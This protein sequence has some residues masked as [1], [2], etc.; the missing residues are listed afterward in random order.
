MSRPLDSPSSPNPVTT[1]NDLAGAV[2]RYGETARSKLANPAAAGAPED[3]LRAPLEELVREIAALCGL[4]SDAVVMVGESS[5]SELKTRPDYAVTVRNALVGFIEV[6]APGKGADPR[7]FRERHDKEQWERLQSIPN[8]LY[9]DGNEFALWR[10]GE[11]TG[12]VIRLRGDVR[13]SGAALAAPAALQATF[14]DFLTWE[15]IAPRTAKQLAGVTARLCRL[16]RDE[17]VEQME[18]GSEALTSLATDW[19]R[20]L[21]PDATDE[22]FADGYAQAVTFGLLVAR[23]R[24]LALSSGLD[25]VARQLGRTDSLIGTAL[26][27]LTDSTENQRTLQTSLGTLVRVLDVVEWSIISRGSPDA[28]LYFYED[29]LEEYDNRL[30]K[31]TGSYYTPPP[32]VETMVRLVHETLKSRFGQ[33]RGLASPQVVVADP[34]VGTGTYLLGVLRRIAAEVEAAEGAGSVPAAVD[35]AIRRLVAFELQLG[36]Y[37][38][39]QLRLVAEITELTGAPPNEALRMFVTDTLANPWAEQENLGAI[40]QPI[41]ESRRRANVIKRDQAITVV[42]GNPPYKEKAKGMG[43]WVESGGANHP[44]PLL[45]WQPPVE[46]NVSAHAKHLRNLYVYFWRWATWKVFDAH[47]TTDRGIVCFITVAG[48]LAGPGFQ[49]MR[50]WLRRKSDEIWVI[51]CSPEGHQPEVNTR[52]FEGVQQPV[53]IVMASRSPATVADVAARVR[54]RALPEG[55]RRDKFAA[56]EALSLDDA[57]WQDCPADWRAPFRPQSTGAWADFAPLDDLFEY[58]GSGVMPGRTWPIAPDAASLERRWN[59]L[60]E[61]P[62]ER[63]EVLFHPHVL[64]SGLGD[65]HVNRTFR[66]GLPGQSARTVSVAADRGEVIAPVRYAFRSFD[67]QWIIP[68][69]RLINRPNPTLWRAHS[70]SQVYLTALE[71]HAPMSG[72]AVTFCGDMP[73]LDHYNGRG[74]RVYPLWVDANGTVP[75]VSKALLSLL[76][77]RVGTPV[78]APDVMAY[79]AAVAAHPA[80][81]RRFAPDLATPGLRIPMTT[82]ADLFTRAVA[83]GKRVIWLHSFGERFAEPAAGRPLGAPRLPADAG[84]IYPRAG[85]IPSSPERFP[86]EI[87]YDPASRRLRVGDGF[88]D[89][90]P[91]EVWR[92]EVSGKQVLRQWFSYR[93][94]TRER[95]IIGNRR[96]PSPLGDIQPERW[97]AEYTSDLIDL[98]HVL[99]GLVALEPQQADLVEEICAGSLLGTAELKAAREAHAASSPGSD[100]DR[101]GRPKARRGRRA[102]SAQADLLG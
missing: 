42:L 30:R 63:K 96:S 60:R 77:E 99:G 72:A 76:T 87:D 89:N 25:P 29:F 75:N 83:L 3:Q 8:L 84:P 28:W 102:D 53:C 34:A 91:P 78:T 67:R 64:K 16:L 2:A 22:R 41:A 17:V 66:E 98:L 9:T 94:R 69:Y 86:D 48:F 45:D 21:F 80:F 23:A 65:R 81:T 32:V 95:P 15:P 56:L 50:D 62:E 92:Y 43:G 20:L 93:R 101:G 73:D 57:G 85:T 19:R 14:E 39:A 26:R 90:V 52:V 24:G 71:A 70:R 40:Y 5:L 54:F 74:G 58:N 11:L 33:Y 35:A 4:A 7:R 46:W 44:A 38:V 61:A 49:R 12:E 82:D 79:L 47:P 68:D 51:D 18:R 31:Q 100:P 10:S 6:K 1:T 36:P 13:D 37:A 55:H 97:P 59:A 88:L 27:L